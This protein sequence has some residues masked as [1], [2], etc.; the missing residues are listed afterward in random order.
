M[1]RRHTT[2]ESNAISEEEFIQNVSNSWHIT[3]P[4]ILIAASVGWLSFRFNSS[5]TPSLVKVLSV[6]G[7]T[8]CTFLVVHSITQS[9][10]LAKEKLQNSLT[11]VMSLF[12]V[13]EQEKPMS[14]V[15]IA[16]SLALLQAFHCDFLSNTSISAQLDSVEMEDVEKDRARTISATRWCRSFIDIF[17]FDD[18]K[19]STKF[20]FASYGFT[21]FSK[22][23]SFWPEF[24]A[25]RLS[26]L[27]KSDETFWVAKAI[28]SY[29]GLDPGSVIA[30]SIG[31]HFYIKH[32][33]RG[34]STFSEDRYGEEKNPY[35]PSF[36]IARDDKKHEVVLSIRGTESID[37]FLVDFTCESVPFLEGKAHRGMLTGAE[38]ILEECFDMLHSMLVSDK[39]SEYSC[40]GYSL[41]I[42][43]HSLGA[44]VA[45]L[46]TL[47]LLCTEKFSLPGVSVR[48]HAFASPPVFS[49]L[50]AIPEDIRVKIT[51]IVNSYDLIPRLSV[52]SM[53]RLVEDLCRIQDLQLPL[54]RRLLL[55]CFP[56]SFPFM[57]REWELFRSLMEEKCPHATFQEIRARSKMEN[58]KNNGLEVPPKL[59]RT[60]SVALQQL[61]SAQLRLAPRLFIVG[62][63]HI[64]FNGNYDNE[65]ENDS[66][67]QPYSSRKVRWAPY[68]FSSNSH[69]LFMD[70][71]PYCPALSRIY[72]TS[73]FLASHFPKSYTNML[74]S[75]YESATSEFN[76]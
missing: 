39:K 73:D 67:V 20:A 50:S 21:R 5:R 65:D 12:A 72:V 56:S 62:R 34:V 3:T 18:V 25:Q 66:V 53:V 32:T 59:S 31:H 63:I 14:R 76:I 35:Q 54:W 52:W 58:Y 4:S 30:L 11:C 23:Q 16:T 51:V 43:G 13:L 22:W 69:H 68:F 6:V 70:V 28:E 2:Y 55:S 75:A 8:F 44:G 41:L 37:D 15:Q 49:P 27:S 9:I 61:R 38:L 40:H 19:R 74:D 33:L 17:N 48:C 46:T 7:P 45:V 10:V 1:P 42:T 26:V 47:I 64:L 36:Y 24:I 29:A 57:K 71:D 60:S